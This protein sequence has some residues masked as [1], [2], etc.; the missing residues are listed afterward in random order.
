MSDSALDLLFNL[1]L[2]INTEEHGAVHHRA[3]GAAWNHH[4]HDKLKFCLAVRSEDGSK[5]STELVLMADWRNEP[6]SMR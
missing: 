6:G 5:Q 2:D 1:F 3:E 4:T